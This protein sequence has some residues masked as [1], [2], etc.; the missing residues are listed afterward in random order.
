M[1][2]NTLLFDVSDRTQLE[3]LGSDRARFLHGLTSNDIK[4]L[5]PGEG[6]ETFLTNLKGKVIAHVYVF[7]GENS[8]WLDGMSDQQAVIVAQLSKYAL[9]DDVQIVDRSKERG[10]LYITGPHVAQLLQLDDTIPLCGHVTR[11]LDGEPLSLRRV[12]LFS[13][14]GFLMSVASSRIPSVKLGLRTVG[15]S[16][17]TQEQFNALRIEAG[18]PRFGVDITDDNLAQ[19][20]AR[21][22]Q[23][24]SFD[25]G[26][27]LGQETIA[28]LDSMGH[29]NRELR[30]VSF[31][32]NL[33]PAP[34]T[35]IFDEA[36]TTE[37]G[38]ITSATVRG[39]DLEEGHEP[40]VVGIALL[41]RAVLTPGC[42]VTFK[43][44]DVMTAGR[45][46]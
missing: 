21:T 17:G 46:L 22:K 31:E 34:S 44:D 12:D 3:I 7:C 33:V 41:R 13:S 23:C 10:E 1:Q 30:R 38:Q 29:T 16:E 40:G 15:V 26:C 43:M 37:V 8:I 20:V 6:C 14:P 9:V 5:K 42:V 39:S 25:K 24:I 35:P 2:T 4:R 27:Y 19:E 18:Y 32:T 36:G 11:E 28:R 45:V